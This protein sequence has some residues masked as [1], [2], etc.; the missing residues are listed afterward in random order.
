MS[1]N[2]YLSSF[3]NKPLHKVVI[4]G[5]HDAGIYD[6]NQIDGT[7]L[8]QDLN[9]YLQAT[10]GVRWFDIRIAGELVGDQVKLKAFHKAMGSKKSIGG[11]QYLKGGFGGF[12]GELEDMLIQARDFLTQNTTEFLIFRISK[13]Q[14][15]F[16]IFVICMAIMQD[17]LYGAHGVAHNLNEK[18]VSDL[19]GKLVVLVSE[20]DAVLIR[21]ELVKAANGDPTSSALDD[22]KYVFSF[23]ELFG[24]KGAVKPYQRTY[25]GLQYYGKFSQTN[26]YDT[27]KSKQKKQMAKAGSSSGMAPEVMGMMY[28]TLTSSLSNPFSLPRNIEKRNKSL[29]T[30]R[31]VDQ[32]VDIWRGGLEDSIKNH[33]GHARY[34]ANVNQ[35]DWD[36]FI[37]N[38]VMLD[39]ASQKLCSVV[40]GLNGISAQVVQSLVRGEWHG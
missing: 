20:D 17:R 40:F 18:L 7:G 39:F 35:Y 9:I 28:W 6:R 26:Y 15:I 12:G 36:G 23:G 21:Q 29:W 8:T 1:L 22:L 19:A 27:N 4:P 2:K 34:N 24:K 11:V 13:S 30:D 14:N 10:V 5:A 32:L 31:H 3:Q 16:M 37:P 33:K 38:I 25:R